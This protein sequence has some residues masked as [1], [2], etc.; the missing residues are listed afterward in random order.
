MRDAGFNRWADAARVVVLYPQTRSSYLPLE[1]EGLLGLVGIHRRRLRHPPRPA[2]AMAGQCQRRPG[3]AAAVMP[4]HAT[5]VAVVE[6]HRRR[7]SPACS[8]WAC[9]SAPR[10][11]PN[12]AR[13]LLGAPLADRLRLSL[14][15]YCTSWTFYGTVTQAQRSG[16]PLPPTFIGTILLYVLGF[17]FLLR[18]VTLAREQNATSHRRPDRHAPGQECLARGDGDVGRGA[19]ASFPTSRCS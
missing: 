16:W 10:C 13:A 5:E 11:G 9:C 14:A 19:R 18:L 2:T 17:G 4:P 7:R 8:G 12:A 3:G 6:Q 15:V 1:P